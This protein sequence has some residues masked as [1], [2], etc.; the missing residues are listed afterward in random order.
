MWF[1]A[2]GVGECSALRILGSILGL[3]SVALWV[4]GRQADI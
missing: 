2:E 1:R 4:W 3:G